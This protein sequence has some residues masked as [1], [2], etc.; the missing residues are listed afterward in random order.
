MTHL[1]LILLVLRCWNSVLARNLVCIGNSA[2]NQQTFDR[3]LGVNDDP[4]ENFAVSVGIS[5]KNDAASAAT[6][7][8]RVFAALFSAIMGSALVL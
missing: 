2:E 6:Q 7:A 3:D 8:K 5:K 4:L 1:R